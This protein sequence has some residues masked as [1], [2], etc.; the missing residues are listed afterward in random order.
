MSIRTQRYR[1]AVAI[2]GIL[3][4]CGARAFDVDTPTSDLRIRWDNTLKYS[5]ASRLGSASSRLIGASNPNFDDGDRNLGAGL[6]SNRVDLLSEFDVTYRDFGIRVSGAA[7][8]DDVYNSS[9]D[10]DSPATYN[11]FSVSNRRFTEATRD[12]HGRKAE[13][14][15]AFAFGKADL[16]E[17]TLR[18]R[19]GRFTQLWGESLFFG[20]NGIAGTRSPTD[21]IKL[22][23]VPGSQFKE[24]IRPTGQVALDWQLTPDLALGGYYPL[25]WEENRIP[26]SGSYFSRSDLL[27]DGGERLLA[28]PPIIAG[29]GPRAFFRGTDMEPDADGQ[30]GVQLR[31][32][33]NVLDTDFGLY[34]VRY[35]DKNFVT[36]L[37]P[38]TTPNAQTGRI[39]TY[40]LVYPK[41]IEA[42][43]VSFARGIGAASIT[44]EISTRRNTPLVAHGGSVVV[45]PGVVADNDD[46]PLY[47]VGNS[48]H[49]QISTVVSL[50]RSSL[51]DGSLLLAEV[52][53]NRRL[54]VDKNAQNL[55]T[56]ATR[57]AYALRAIFMPTWYQVLSGLDV[58]IPVGVGYAPSGRSSVITLWN[59]GSSH[60]GDMSIGLSTDYLQTWKATLNLTHYFGSEGTVLDS[61][62]SFSFKQS[63]KDRDFVSLSIQRTF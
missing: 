26:A 44:G 53:F 45:A 49:A 8:Y 31:W 51:W 62:N 30:Y 1:L 5:A 16:G 14:L 47:P 56:N 58:T 59:G 11:A 61:T 25:E 35:H 24:L 50:G 4:A 10:N 17:T 18:F 13:L 34:A 20:D 57:D 9:T 43:G 48:L 41:N 46:H 63:L 6:I 32:R 3:V 27:G 36:H 54:S 42:Y 37:F 38:S 23:S 19:G 7:W 55:E 29:G 33:S 15:D 22:L 40:A 52:A 2:A 39:G 60:G 21:L 12:L 28:G